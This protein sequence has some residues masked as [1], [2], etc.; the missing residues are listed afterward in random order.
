M[1]FNGFRLFSLF[2]LRNALLQLSI[3]SEFGA[4]FVGPTDSIEIGRFGLNDASVT[5]TDTFNSDRASYNFFDFSLENIHLRISRKHRINWRIAFEPDRWQLDRETDATRT[6]KIRDCYATDSFDDWWIRSTQ[7]S[8]SICAVCK[9]DINRDAAW[10]EN[11]EKWMRRD[12]VKNVSSVGCW[13]GHFFGDCYFCLPFL[14]IP[15]DGYWHFVL[16][17]EIYTH[18]MPF[19]ERFCLVRVIIRPWQ[20]NKIILFVWLLFY[21]FAWLIFGL[22]FSFRF[23]LLPLR[24]ILWQWACLSLSVRFIRSDKFFDDISPIRRFRFVF[25][26]FFSL[27]F[28]ASYAFCV[29]NENWCRF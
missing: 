12:A 9:F 13:S 27:L 26:R 15:S 5:D 19:S 25:S 11:H 24:R 17:T 7:K 10:N 6:R 16:F 18:L 28:L 1:N 23:V 3:F 21:C 4:A 2:P 8:I 22:L 20:T 14:C 29:A